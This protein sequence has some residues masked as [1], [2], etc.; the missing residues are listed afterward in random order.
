MQ[1]SWVDHR[2]VRDGYID[3]C[4]HP[5]L[6][7][8]LFLVTVSDAKGLSYYSDRSIMRRLSMERKTLDDARASLIQADIIAYETPLYQVLGLDRVKKPRRRQDHPVCLKQI[9]KQAGGIS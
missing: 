1:F 7:L 8:Y 5:A 4:G 6:A 3:L 2:L 9:F